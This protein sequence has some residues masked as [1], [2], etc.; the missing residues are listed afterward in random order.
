MASD[1]E[2]VVQASKTLEKLLEDRYA[3]TGRGLHEKIS[4][5]ENQLNV[6]LTRSLRFIAT[7]RNKLVHETEAGVLEDRD[8]FEEVVADAVK[9]LSQPEKP[10]TVTASSTTPPPEPVF[11]PTSTRSQQWWWNKPVSQIRWL[12]STRWWWNKPERDRTPNEKNAPMFALGVGIF[13]FLF[14]LGLSLPACLGFTALAYL[15][16]L[17]FPQQVGAILFA[18]FV[19]IAVIWVFSSLA[20]IHGC[21]HGNP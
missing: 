11:Q 2:L 14:T 12:P 9:D 17:A 10:R 13:A 16:T 18:F 20:F 15:S 1:L 19:M 3:A 5:V 21:L 8:R 4:S 7:V 6:S